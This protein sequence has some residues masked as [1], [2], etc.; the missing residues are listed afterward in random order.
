MGGCG[1]GG[2]YLVAVRD[3]LDLFIGAI[4]R[5]NYRTRGVVQD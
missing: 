4:N 5:L 2:S 3:L 1:I